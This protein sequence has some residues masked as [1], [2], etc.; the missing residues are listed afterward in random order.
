MPHGFCIA[1]RRSPPAENNL[2]V[3]FPRTEPIWC[4]SGIVP[5]L[6]SE[7]SSSKSRGAVGSIHQLM[8]NLGILCSGLLGY[9]LVEDVPHGWRYVQGF[10]V[11][12]AVVQVCGWGWGCVP[13]YNNWHTQKLQGNPC[14]RLFRYGSV[15]PL[16]LLSYSQEGRAGRQDRRSGRSSA[17][18]GALAQSPKRKRRNRRNTKQV[19][20]ER[21]HTAPPAAAAA[22]AAA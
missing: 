1:G 11:V 14:R 2:D 17:P 20:S 12:P 4:G 10:I 18:A 8:I 7:V 19:R 21:R 3:I 22:A 9:A 16:R 5:V 13:M 6:L 15:G